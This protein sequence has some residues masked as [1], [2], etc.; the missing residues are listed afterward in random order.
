VRLVGVISIVCLAACTAGAPPMSSLP[1][2]QIPRVPNISKAE[3]PYPDD[4]VQLVTRRLLSRG[5]QA[6]LSAPARYEPWSIN[7][8]VG[9]SSCLKRANASVTLVIF[10][11]G[12][13]VGTAATAPAGTCESATYTPIQREALP[14]EDPNAPLREPPPIGGEDDVARFE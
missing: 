9:W 4:Y 1:L 11:A 13:I 7:E 3:Q 12:K 10:G 5:E 2:P 14:V 8:A 6:E